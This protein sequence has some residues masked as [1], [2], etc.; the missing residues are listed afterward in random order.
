MQSPW[1]CH[2]GVTGALANIC[3]VSGVE[4][5]YTEHGAMT[6]SDGMFVGGGDASSKANCQQ[7]CTDN[8]DCTHIAYSP[9]NSNPGSFNCFLY[10]G[11]DLTAAPQGYVVFQQST[12]A[13]DCEYHL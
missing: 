10:K 3:F 8:A 1:G 13:V 12:N 2:P 4:V 9:R 6:I 7:S 5:T 11:G